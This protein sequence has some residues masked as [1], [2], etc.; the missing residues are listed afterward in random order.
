MGRV[1]MTPIRC[2]YSELNVRMW[3]SILIVLW[4]RIAGSYLRIELLVAQSIFVRHA[5][6]YRAT[7]PDVG[8]EAEYFLKRGVRM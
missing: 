6:V 2:Q 5:A 7:M 3:V 4:V 1:E 8:C